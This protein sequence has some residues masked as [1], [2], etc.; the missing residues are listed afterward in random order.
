MDRLCF[1]AWIDV[2]ILSVGVYVLSAHLVVLNN[3]Q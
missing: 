3:R 2:G 1:H